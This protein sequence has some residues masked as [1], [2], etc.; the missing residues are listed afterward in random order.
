MTT[1][2]ASVKIIQIED[3]F[4]DSQRNSLLVGL[5]DDGIVYVWDRNR[6]GWNEYGLDY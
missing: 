3:R 4:E 5:G 2:P 6:L 1:K